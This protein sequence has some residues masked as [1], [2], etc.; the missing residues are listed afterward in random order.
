MDRIERTER[1]AAMGL[2]ILDAL[3]VGLMIVDG[4]CVPLF[5]NRAAESLAERCSP[6]L[7][8]TRGRAISAG[9]ADQTRRLRSLV[10][11]TAQGGSGG[12]MIN[13]A[14]PRRG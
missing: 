4:S 1:K 3:S 11:A 13:A 8:P 14:V 10:F 2:E 9:T 7:L 5:I 12:S 6:A